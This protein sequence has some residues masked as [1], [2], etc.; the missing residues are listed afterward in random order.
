[1]KIIF[2]GSDEFAAVSLSRLITDGHEIAAVVTPPDRAQ[3]RGMNVMILPVKM[4]AL[5]RMIPI[6]QPE[7]LHEPAFQEALRSFNA[8]LFVVIVY[9]KFLPPAILEMPKIFCINVHASLLPKYRGAAPVNQAILDGEC[10]TGVTVIRMNERMDAGDMI[11][12]ESVN[13]ADD[14][15]ARA[16]REQLADLGAECLSRAVTSLETGEY[17]LIPQDDTAASFTRKLTRE[18]GCIDWTKSAR[19]IHNLVRGLVPW[20]GAYTL[21]EDKRLKV[22]KTSVFSEEPSQAPA[23]SVLRLVPEGIVTACGHGSLLLKEV[24]L[25]SARAMDARSF[26]V[27]HSVR[28]GMIFGGEK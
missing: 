7:D 17:T 8:D 19:G 14:I 28:T 2:F 25:E 18:T 23:G 27:G 21:F 22:L 6:L 15:D 13:V 5:E 16:L 11:V 9:G 3:G 20:P 26:S 12:Q 1:M 4:T 10:R 24:Q